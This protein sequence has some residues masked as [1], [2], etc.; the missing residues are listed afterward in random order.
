RLLRH[1]LPAALL[2]ALLAGGI[3]LGTSLADTESGAAN[4]RTPSVPSTEGSAP[5]TAHREEDMKAV[6]SVP[7]GYDEYARQGNA[8]SQPRIV[9]YADDSE[10]VQ[11]RLTQWDKAPRSPMG[12]AKEA[13]AGWD[14]YNGDARTQY[15]RTSVDGHE[16]VLADTTYDLKEYPTRVME[17]MILTDD[18]RMYELRVDMPKGTADEKKGTAAFKGVRDRLEIGP[19]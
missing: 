15:T 13:H 9:V 16:A 10:T 4:D 19:N 6:L 1:P 17:L 14:R 8:A 5:W 3:W 11:I 7:A 12:Q 18:S 2:G